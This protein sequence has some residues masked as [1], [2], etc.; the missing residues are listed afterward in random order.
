MNNYTKYTNIMLES[1][2]FNPK[3]QELVSKKTEI[4]TAI[5]AHYNN[6]PT[7]IL[8]VGFCP[9]I[10]G[11][12]C[13]NISVTSVTDDAVKLLD[14]FN[15]AYTHI[16]ESSLID[17]EN[18]FDW[19]VAGDEFFTFAVD[20]DEQRSKVGLL[21]RLAKDMV[22]TT[23]RDYKNQDFNGREFSQPLAVRNATDTMVF[24]EFNDYAYNERNFWKSTVYQVE[25]TEF[26]AHGTF[27]RASMYFKQLAKFSSDAG[28]QNF[29]V[30]KNLM[31]KSLIKKNYEHVISI[32]IK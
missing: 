24:L 8:F 31:Y 27:S 30:H 6:E 7:S 2:K 20:E 16:P 26:T 21:I 18:A 13:K 12:Q 11:T 22:V 3:Y 19:V 4:L 17:M 9:W 28:A 25:N 23:L 15:I 29:L 32:P 5:S 14:K 10:L 1:F